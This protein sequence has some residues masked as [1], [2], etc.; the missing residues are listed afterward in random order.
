MSGSEMYIIQESGQD[1]IV[2]P[3]WYRTRQEAARWDRISDVT[4]LSVTLTCKVSPGLQD[5]QKRVW[6]ILAEQNAEKA[7][8]NTWIG[9]MVVA[10]SIEELIGLIKSHAA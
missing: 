3:D 9:R 1:H 5:L 4:D 7:K 2:T 6:R 8:E 10:E